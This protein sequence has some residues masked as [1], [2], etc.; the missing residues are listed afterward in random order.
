M[1]LSIEADEK[2]VEVAT[3]DVIVDIEGDIAM[4]KLLYEVSFPHLYYS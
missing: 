1:P 2:S 4:L 3:V